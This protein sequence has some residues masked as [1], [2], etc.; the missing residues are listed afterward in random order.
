MPETGKKTPLYAW[1]QAQGALVVD[2]GGWDMPLWYKTG[3]VKE[4]LA[5]IEAAGLFDTSHMAVLRLDGPDAFSL[6]QHCFT[7]D[8]TA[9]VGPSAGPLA[10]GR[11]VYGAFLTAD[12]HALDDAIVYKTG[13]EAFM[14]VVNANMGPVVAA[15]LEAHRAGRTVRIQDL[16]AR[17]GKM[18]LQG[19][20]AGRIIKKVL[21]DPDRVLTGLPYFSFKGHFDPSAVPEPVFTVDGTPILLS[22]TGYTGEF[23]FELFMAPEAA[24]KVW[25]MILE[26]G[27][28]FGLIPCGLAA[29][30]SLR[31]GAMLPLSHQD[32][33]HWP[34]VNHPWS[35]AL[36]YNAAGNGFT[37]SFV[38]DVVLGL[39]PKADH[40]VAYVGRDPR[41]AALHDADGKPA[42]VVDAQ[43]REIGVV[44][45]SVADM[46]LGL[47]QGRIVSLSDP[48]RPAGAKFKGLVC[49]FIRV[50]RLLDQGEEVEIRDAKRGLKVQVVRDIRPFRTAR[51]P[52]KDML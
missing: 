9:C 32:I 5:V 17:L 31:A 36:P 13:P 46:A 27:R 23:G 40:T 45:T 39:A 14:V 2:F 30:D 33:G 52:L 51:K 34:F 35:F 20:L 22:R 1:H 19:P 6:L 49:G 21:K 12:G 41:K 15:H 48:N 8:L 4:H 42:V 47:D 16:S 37:K 7:K 38:G 44:L 28:E 50:N 10:P 24:A 11:C 18:D 26:A 3:A 29:R 25:D 43:G